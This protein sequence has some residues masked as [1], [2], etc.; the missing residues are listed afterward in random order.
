ME[1]EDE[2]D[3]EFKRKNAAYGVVVEKA[4]QAGSIEKVHRRSTPN[5]TPPLKGGV[6]EARANRPQA[7]WWGDMP[8]KKLPPPNRPSHKPLGLFDSPSRGE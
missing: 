5:F 1:A 6:N 4:L 2:G 8:Q 7:S 3:P